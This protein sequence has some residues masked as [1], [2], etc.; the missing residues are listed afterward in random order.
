MKIKQY[1]ALVLA[2]SLAIVS[3]AYADEEKN[4]SVFI[5]KENE[6]NAV[7]DLKIDGSGSKFEVPDLNEGESR[8]LSNN[9]MIITVTKTDG[10]LVVTTADGEE[11][12]LPNADHKAMVARIKALHTLDDV[13]ADD[14]IKIL[15][16][17][18]SDDQKETIKASIAAAGI[19]KP[20]K[21]LDNGNFAFVIKEEFDGH[22]IHE[23]EQEFEWVSEDGNHKKVK[24][25]VIKK[26][27]DN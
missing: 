23:G 18:L 1:L 22:D 16:Q 2:S 3:N 9:G 6:K 25:I 21:F 19:T 4:I 17:S 20:V 8:T 12:V 15:A 14:S 7:L 13:K 24:R 10:N 26:Q 5:N 11:I 27:E